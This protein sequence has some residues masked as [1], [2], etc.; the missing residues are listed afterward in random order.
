[1]LGVAN[2]YLNVI[3]AYLKPRVEIPCSWSNGY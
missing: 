2:I 1:M 3:I